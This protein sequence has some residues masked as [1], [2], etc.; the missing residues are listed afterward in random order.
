M[1]KPYTIFA[2]A[3]LAASLLSAS[4][5]LAQDTAESQASILLA[6][7]SGLT[8]RLQAAGVQFP[9]LLANPCGAAVN[10]AGVARATLAVVADGRVYLAAGPTPPALET[11][12]GPAR[13]IPAVL[14]M[15]FG[16]A[17]AAVGL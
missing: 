12:A 9:A 4:P 6:D 7:A 5:A 8:I 14:A 2:V 1:L 16:R 10:T 15:L 3:V 11:A 13:G 17:T